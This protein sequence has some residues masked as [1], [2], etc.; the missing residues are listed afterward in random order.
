MSTISDLATFQQVFAKALLGGATPDAFVSQPAFSIYRNTVRKG[1]IDAL[2]ANYPAVSRVVGGEWFRSAAAL[3]VEQS[4]PTD[5][6]LLRY[7]ADFAA[8][9]DAFEPAAALPYLPGV[10]RLD[11]CWTEAHIAADA[12]PLDGETLA[13]HLAKAPDTLALTPHP[14]ARWAWF[15]EHPI[16]TIW[17]RN[18]AAQQSDAPE[19]EWH[20]EG[21]LLTRPGDTVQWCEIGCA[22][23]AF[24]DACACGQSIGAAAD[25]ALTAQPDADL[26]QVLARLLRAGAFNCLTE[27]TTG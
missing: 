9:L 19:L 17:Q 18:R 24:L 6:R 3:H 22:E 26:S 20:A 7:G 25:A 1:C 21:A 5:S 12:T 10:A 8:F 11:R 13:R 15:D 23:V 16:F 14:A 4:P 27:S 2:E